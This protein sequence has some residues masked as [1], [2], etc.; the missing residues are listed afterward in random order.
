[1]SLVPFIFPEFAKV[2]LSFTTF[3]LKSELGNM[4]RSSFDS[5]FLGSIGISRSLSSFVRKSSI[6]MSIIGLK[7]SKLSS[8]RGYSLLWKS[9]PEPE[10]VLPGG[11][12]ELLVFLELNILC[13][14]SGL[15]SLLSPSILYGVLIK[16]V[17]CS[18][19]F[20]VHIW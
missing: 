15:S 14:F 4:S 3:Q 1:M 2:S 16:L 8:G 17:H 18:V 19:L 5:S 7:F 6:F 11:F 10:S 12:I 13:M 20:I 9:D